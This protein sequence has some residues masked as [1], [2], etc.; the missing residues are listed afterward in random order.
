MKLNCKLILLRCN[1]DIEIKLSY[2]Q[3]PVISMLYAPVIEQIK[4][5]RFRLTFNGN[6]SP[7]SILVACYSIY[8]RFPRSVFLNNF[9][10]GKTTIPVSV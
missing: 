10:M 5:K 1:I 9:N 3:D 2:F 4:L 7:E 6:D 8:A